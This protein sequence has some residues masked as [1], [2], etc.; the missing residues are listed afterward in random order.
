MT[1]GQFVLFP[2][3]A[4]IVERD[5]RQRRE[6]P[7]IDGLAE[8]IRT[9]GLIHPI[10]ITR[11]GKLIAGERRLTACR[12]IGWTD[13]PAQYADTLDPLE[14]HM[15]ELE[16]NVRRVDLTWVE[17]ANAIEE[18]H[19]MKLRKNPDQTY[20]D[21][22]S[23]LNLGKA[24]VF[25]HIMVAK[26]IKKDPSIAELDKFST[27][28]GIVQ[29]KNERAVATTIREALSVQATPVDSEPVQAQ[30]AQRFAEIRHANFL[31]WVKTPLKTP[32]NFVHCDFPYGVSTGD[33][34]GQSAAKAFGTYEDGEDIYFNLLINM[35][36]HQ[37]NFIAP[38]A[39]LMFWFSMNYYS[40]TIEL[41]QRYGWAVNPMPL[42]WGKSDNAGIIP[43]TN[44]GPRQ[45]YE[46]ALLCSR[47][48]R[49]IVKPVANLAWYPT[50]KEYHTSEKSLSMLSHFFRM[51][52]DSSTTMIDPTCG[53]GMA[54]KAAEAAGAMY[55][56]GLE[57][58]LDFYKGACH[59]LRLGE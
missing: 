43:D 1:S 58:D 24:T 25:E 2:V 50:T 52:V 16:E 11:E 34:K 57:R 54:V 12:S 32:F 56:L 3:A 19:Q 8:S 47:G 55:A 15:I 27:A 10:V 6:L 40:R 14:L 22:A 26:E 36:N 30:P 39:H 46:T 35:L 5:T 4:I 48:D 28:R 45:I 13:I 44:R 49:K 9:T 7:D 53:S 20:E 21:T 38:S 17:R 42:I 29:R 18:F 37:D 23:A 59:N 31:E 51:L 33:K 41:L